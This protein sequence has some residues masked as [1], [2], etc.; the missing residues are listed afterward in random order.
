[1]AASPASPPDTR[2]QSI[3]RHPTAPTVMTVNGHFAGVGEEPTTEQ[4]EHG[5][6]VIDEDQN[7]KCV[8][9][10]L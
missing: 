1:M 3:V 9:V 5:I 6:Q 2:P 8:V 7:F 10:E 4:Y